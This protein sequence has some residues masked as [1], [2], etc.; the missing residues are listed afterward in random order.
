MKHI[1]IT[2]ASRIKVGQRYRTRIKSIS[3]SSKYV[4]FDFWIEPR[5]FLSGYRLKTNIVNSGKNK[6]IDSILYTDLQ[7]AKRV[8]FRSLCF[9]YGNDQLCPVWKVGK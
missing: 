1:T 3:G 8:A 7:S 2:K 4:Y 6:Q 9:E 5:F